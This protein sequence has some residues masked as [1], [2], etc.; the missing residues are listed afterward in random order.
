L[1]LSDDGTGWTGTYHITIAEPGSEQSQVVQ[2]LGILIP[3]EQAAPEATATAV[4]FGSDGWRQY[5]PELRV[6][7]Q[8]Q[9]PDTQLAVLPQLT[10]PER[11]R[12]LLEQSIRSHAPAYRE[13]RITS[14]RPQVLRYHPGLRCTIGYHLTYASDVAAGH[15]WPAFVVAK[16]Y[17]GDKGQHAYDSMN[18]LWD[19]PLGTS[20]V[21]R[22]AEPLAYLP[23]LQL[24]MQGPIPMEQTLRE[25][26]ESA[27]HAHTP[28]A[29]TD[30]DDY[31]RKTAVGLAALHSAGVGIGNEH[32]WE[33]ELAGVRAFVQRLTAAVPGL[34]TAATPLFTYLEALATTCPSDPLVP[35]HGT[36]RPAQVLLDQGQIGF[37]DF[38]SFCQAEPAMDL[39]LFMVA[40]ID[41]GMSAVSPEESS[42]TEPAINSERMDRL[43]QL[44]AIADRFLAHYAALRPVSRPR[45]A[46]WEALNILELVIRSWDRVKPMRLN[47][48]ILM[49][50]RHLRAQLTQPGLH[51]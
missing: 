19:S 3:P 49:L 36:F 18:A 48:T 41:M 38:D 47:H 44:E 11:A 32:R 43:I 6:L 45:V 13:L 10:D 51:G 26:L 7:L 14:C 15:N 1:L 28:E 50:E 30:L 20:E 27:L 24:L 23:E 39:A 5:V 29:L 12:A 16:T 35:T 22:I 37:I 40:T 9:L 8:M 21:V 4:T 25:L 34:A 33:D 46:V 17:D 42:A 31:I 2:L